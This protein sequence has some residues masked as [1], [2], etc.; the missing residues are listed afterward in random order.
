MLQPKK[1]PNDDFE[2]KETKAKI[3][4]AA[5]RKS[6]KPGV[7]AL[8]QENGGAQTEDDISRWGAEFR[9]F[10]SDPGP[11]YGSDPDPVCT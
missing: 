6:A 10:W 1:E 2:M 9:V 4:R 11:V 5:P 3:L 7:N 8:K